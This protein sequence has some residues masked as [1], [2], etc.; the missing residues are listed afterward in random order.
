MSLESVH[1]TLPRQTG[2]PGGSRR[3]L[4]RLRRQAANPTSPRPAA[5][6]A[7]VAGSGLGM[8]PTPNVMLPVSRLSYLPP[9]QIRSAV[10]AM[11]A[12]TSVLFFPSQPPSPPLVSDFSKRL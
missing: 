9:S 10:E 2:R 7:N 12:R 8:T 5:R 3:S 6:R 4:F 11:P 1:P